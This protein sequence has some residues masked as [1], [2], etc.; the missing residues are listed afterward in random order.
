[1]PSINV[2]TA[3]LILEVFW[4]FRIGQSNQSVDTCFK[5]LKIPWNIVVLFSTERS[6]P[7]AN[8]YHHTVILELLSTRHRCYGCQV[9]LSVVVLPWVLLMRERVILPCLSP[10]NYLRMQQLRIGVNTSPTLADFR[11]INE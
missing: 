9:A 3:N 10:S 7:L 2:C 6:T 11:N 1:M 5:L 8:V 4:C